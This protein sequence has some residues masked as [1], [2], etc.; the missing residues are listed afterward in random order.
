[1]PVAPGAPRCDLTMDEGEQF[2]FTVWQV[3]DGTGEEGPRVPYPEGTTGYLDIR[4]RVGDAEAVLRFGPEADA[5][6]GTVGVIAEDGEVRVLLSDAALSLSLPFPA[7]GVGRYDLFILPA[8]DAAQRFRKMW[9]NVFYR[10][11]VTL[12]PE[13]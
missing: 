9:G 2:G 5:L 10:R 3:E 12:Q 13:A 11:R 8:G 6:D 4:A 1:M 7:D